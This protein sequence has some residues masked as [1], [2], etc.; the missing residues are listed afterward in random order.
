MYKPNFMTTKK[1]L[2][3]ELIEDKDVDQTIVKSFYL[4]DELCPDVWEKSGDS[5]KMIEKVRKKL[6]NA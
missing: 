4:K 3:D 6:L 5:Y 2:V 1:S